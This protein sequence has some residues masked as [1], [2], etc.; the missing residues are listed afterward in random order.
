VRQLDS[1]R[2]LLRSSAPREQP[3]TAAHEGSLPEASVPLQDAQRGETDHEHTAAL[4]AARLGIS[5]AA[6][7]NVLEREV[8]LA[9]AR[10]DKALATMSAW[11]P[12]S[13]AVDL[14]QRIREAEDALAETQT[15]LEQRLR[16]SQYPPP[17]ATRLQQI[18][19]E[20]IV[21]EEQF[22]ACI[23]AGDVREAARVAACAAGQTM[24][25]TE[26][27][28]AFEALGTQALFEYA[29]AL[30]EAGEWAKTVANWQ[31]SLEWRL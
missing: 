10:R 26:T 11:A 1:R 7:P 18:A 28:E 5:A 9:T 3:L 30:V 13:A 8:H 23:A 2:R 4:L 16:A 21:C 14:R 31:R 17:A 15:A 29:C 19:E 22:E 24:Q 6:D 27:W 12:P 25:T 20:I